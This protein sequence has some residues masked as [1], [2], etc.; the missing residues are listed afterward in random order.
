[1]TS[2]KVWKFAW[3]ALSLLILSQMV[4]CASANKMIASRRGFNRE[5][6]MIDFY[7]VDSLPIGAT[8]SGDASF[9]GAGFHGKKAAD[10]STY[11][12]NALTCAH[13]TLP[14]NTK[15]KVTLASTGKSV[16]VKVTDRGPYEDGRIIDLSVAAAKEIGLY[17]VGVGE[18]QAEVVP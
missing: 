13:K 11:D 17:S 16:Q 5:Q 3:V 9:Y 6:H 1:M 12:Q 10:G 18:V 8:F 7:K 14:F 15:L 2:S 4:G